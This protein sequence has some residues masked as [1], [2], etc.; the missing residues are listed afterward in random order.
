MLHI[1]IGLRSLVLVSQ[2]RCLPT[3]GHAVLRRLRR[4]SY[5]RASLTEFTVPRKW[6]HYFKTAFSRLRGIG[7]SV[8]YILDRIVRFW[9]QTFDV[10]CG[11][12]VQILHC[13][14]KYVWVYIIIYDILKNI[15]LNM[16]DRSDPANPLII[17]DIALEP[18]VAV[19]KHKRDLLR[20]PIKVRLRW[21]LSF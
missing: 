1:T 11:D 20:L 15:P 12:L 18:E 5:V 6:R 10:N 2:I 7:E 17:Y 21:H 13:I 16:P 8:L 9:H 3:L 4:L 14:S 19:L